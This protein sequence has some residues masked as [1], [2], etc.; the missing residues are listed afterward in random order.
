MTAP[1]KNYVIDTTGPVVIVGPDGQ[2]FE[3]DLNPGRAD[4]VTT[5]GVEVWIERKT[6][7]TRFLDAEGNQVGPW[8]Q[9]LVPAI[10]WARHA[11]WRDPSDPDWW[12]DLVIEDVRANSRRKGEPWPDAP[13]GRGG[14]S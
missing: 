14:A 11:G 3:V 13:L 8:H 9:N 4:Y 2:S 5:D 1:A 6:V 12:N 10:V 7:K